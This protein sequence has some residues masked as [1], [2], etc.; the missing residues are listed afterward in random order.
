[1]TLKV[2]SAEQIL[3]CNILASDDPDPAAHWS[4]P[5]QKLQ[6]DSV[7]LFHMVPI[8]LWRVPSSHNDYTPY[9]LLHT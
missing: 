9:R 7:D 6:S 5:E 3:D 2:I 4:I 8:L 1:M